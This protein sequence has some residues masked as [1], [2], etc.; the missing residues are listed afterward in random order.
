M[1][2]K[3]I[4]ITNYPV[5]GTDCIAYVTD[6]VSCPGYY[7]LVVTNDSSEAK[8]YGDEA[9]LIR[10]AL[11]GIQIKVAAKRP[12]VWHPEGG[13]QLYPNLEVI[14]ADYAVQP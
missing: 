13:V 5:Q 7:K 11:E 14:Q 12:Q 3:I 9:W 6:I 8:V 2:S 10:I 1:M 4:K